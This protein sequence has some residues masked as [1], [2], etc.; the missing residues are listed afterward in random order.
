M[1]TESSPLSVLLMISTESFHLLV[2]RNNLD[3]Q[4]G[5]SRWL[6]DI[7]LSDMMTFVVLALQLGHELK[8]TLHSYPDWG[9]SYPDWGFF[10]LFPEL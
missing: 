8:D 7:T 5:P 1:N 2:E 3:G 4:A 10:L 9:F 6:P